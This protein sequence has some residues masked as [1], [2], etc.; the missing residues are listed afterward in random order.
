MTSAAQHAWLMLAAGDDRQHGGND[1]YDDQPDVHYSWDSTVPNH[2]AVTEGDLIALWDKHQVIGASVI[3]AIE[4]GADNKILRRCPSCDR[5][6]IKARKTG[7][8]K[9]KCYKCGV[10]FNE[11]VTV[12]E[13]VTT[14]RSRHDAGWTNLD[15]CL[16]GQQLRALCHSPKSQLSIRSLRWD[17]FRQAVEHAGRG[18][19]LER[20]A[21]REPPLAGG[22][23]RATVRVRIGQAAFRQRLLTS[24]GAVCAFTGPAP[25]AVLDA[26]HLYSY[27]DVGEHHTHGGLLLRR[28]IHRLFDD[29]DLSF[30]PATNHIDV[31]PSVQGYAM[32]AALHG[33]PLHVEV[34]PEQLTWLKQHH[35][36][37]RSS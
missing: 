18:D 23:R 2:A 27:A 19:Y 37:H 24:Y 3:E 30:D 17:D 29:G 11:P 13:S 4:P 21:F 22:H 8:P 9:Y 34:T 15:G 6:G 1:G 26:G 10:E 12:I 5:A 35:E 36:Q 32:Y 16:T 25:T 7:A 31:K 14:Y 28:D 33:Q 20:L